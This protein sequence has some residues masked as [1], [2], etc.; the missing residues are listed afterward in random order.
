MQFS[1]WLAWLLQQLFIGLTEN[2][3]Y[4]HK[5]HQCVS[6]A[7]TVRDPAR[8]DRTSCCAH[9]KTHFHIVWYVVSTN[10]TKLLHQRFSVAI[11]IRELKLLTLSIAHIA[12][13]AGPI[14]QLAILHDHL[15]VI[16]ISQV[17]AIG[18][19][20]EVTPFRDAQF[21]QIFWS[22]TPK[23]LWSGL[24]YKIEINF[25][26]LIE[27]TPNKYIHQILNNKRP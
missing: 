4:E 1:P 15:A 27:K 21:E 14:D 11:N 23:V 19:L 17:T 16:D 7:K 18:A 13:I 3:L 25:N 12:D 26:H 20:A 6:A 2:S 24:Q 5:A 8:E 9:Q 10:Q 22:G